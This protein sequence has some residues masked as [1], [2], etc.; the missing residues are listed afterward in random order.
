MKNIAVA[1]SLTS[2]AF[3]LGSL[4]YVVISSLLGAAF[5]GLFRM[6]MYHEAHPFQYIGIVA[7]VFGIIG[8][9]WVRFFG[10]TEGWKRWTS[11]LLC[12]VL[13]IIAASV[14][15]GILWKIHDMQAG[16]FTE[17]A[18]FWRDL[19]WGA[20]EGLLVGWFVILI[21]IPYNLI[22]LLIGGLLLHKIP[23]VISQ[24]ANQGRTRRRSQHLPRRE[25]KS[26]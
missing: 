7:I 11:I 12:M 25:F 9:G 13:T 8:A 24:G 16:Y 26:S 21:S 6:F 4:G 15:G 3:L 14:P 23:S 19:W 5:G 2:F 17:G 1:L 18:R 10:G 20:K 22:G